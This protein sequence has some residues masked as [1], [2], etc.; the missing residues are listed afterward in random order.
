M[1]DIV[2]PYQSDK[3]TLSDVIKLF[4][5]QKVEMITNSVYKKFN[6]MQLA[7][8][9]ISPIAAN[10]TT[11]SQFDTKHYQVPMENED[12]PESGRNLPI[13]HQMPEMTTFAPNSI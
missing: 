6:N 3:I 11:G 9:D 12:L 5:S 2:D 10:D 1:L 7:P 13:S 4:S 8:L